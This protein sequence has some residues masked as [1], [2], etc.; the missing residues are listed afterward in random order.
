MSFD[1]GVNV[2]EERL[3]PQ[4][5]CRPRHVRFQQPRPIHQR[6]RGVVG[7]LFQRG[8][9]S[10]SRAQRTHVFIDGADEK[11][12]SLVESPRGK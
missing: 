5:V 2:V 10:R 7:G 12:P 6:R 1:G 9:D 3:V 11:L 4:D 8:K